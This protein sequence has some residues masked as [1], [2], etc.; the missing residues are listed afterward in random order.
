MANEFNIKLNKNNSN[1]N[2]SNNTKEGGFNVMKVVLICLAILFILV[3]IYV[4]VN[5]YN[6]NQINCYQ[7]RDFTDYLFSTDKNV[8]ILFDKPI[9]K[10]NVKVKKE[11]TPKMGNFLDKKEVFHIANQDYSYEQSKCKCA[12]YGGRLATKN[13][14]TNAY[15]NGANW[16]SYGW[17]E[18]QNAYYPVQQCYYDSIME[19]DEFLENS[20]KYCGKPG[21]NGG[22]FSN[23]Q[24]KFGVNC[25]GPKPKGAVI[26]PKSAYCPPQDFCKLN[27]NSNANQK[28]STDE[29]VPFSDTRWNN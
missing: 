14:V 12:S 18:G 28:L 8:C 9:P 29:I 26:K 5:Y 11:T 3:L 22:Y 6:Y 7:K 16:C 21:L 19:E 10:P 24:L 20:D 1:I 2:T 15:N 13:E 4:G 25:Y 17:T 27:K 23:P